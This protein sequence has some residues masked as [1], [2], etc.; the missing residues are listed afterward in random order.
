MHTPR[1]NP[2]TAKRHYP[3]GI[4]ANS[5]IPSEFISKAPS[6]SN[7]NAPPPRNGLGRSTFLAV[8]FLTALSAYTSGP[9]FPPSPI[10]LLFPCPA[11]PASDPNSDESKAYLEDLE[12]Q[13]L[14]LPILEELR[15]ASDANEWH[16]ALKTVHTSLFEAI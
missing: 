13:M 11:P 5:T 16:E 2:D 15:K 8:T 6:G 12:K 9:L 4:I 3:G 10:S 14:S 7:S 1:H